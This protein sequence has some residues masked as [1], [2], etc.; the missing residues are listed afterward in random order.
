MLGFYSFGHMEQVVVAGKYDQKCHAFKNIKNWTKMKKD[1][2][3]ANTA[4]FST[5]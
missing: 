4:E 2:R 1:N 3:K 5:L